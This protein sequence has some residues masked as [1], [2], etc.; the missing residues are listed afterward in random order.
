VDRLHHRVADAVLD[1]DS[2]ARPMRLP[3]VVVE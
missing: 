1:E 3:D 2:L